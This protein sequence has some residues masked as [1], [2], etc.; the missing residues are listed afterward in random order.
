MMN[1]KI[2]KWRHRIAILNEIL[3]LKIIFLYKKLKKK[4]LMKMFLFNF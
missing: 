4:N 2:A 1:L 3:L